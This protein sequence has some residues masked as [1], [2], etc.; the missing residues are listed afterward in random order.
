MTSASLCM[1][2]IEHNAQPD[3]FKNVFSGIWWAASTLLTVGYGDIYPVTV[4]GK[5]LGII[6]GYEQYRNINKYCFYYFYK[7]YFRRLKKYDK[8]IF[9]N[10]SFTFRKRRTCRLYLFATNIRRKYILSLSSI[11]YV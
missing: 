1:Y 9:T 6:R 2:S 5:L 10:Y 7:K 11:I 4:M 8:K 3:T